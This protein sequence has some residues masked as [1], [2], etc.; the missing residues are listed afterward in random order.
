MYENHQFGVVCLKIW[1]HRPSESEILGQDPSLCI[2]KMFLSDS[3]AFAVENQKV[4]R[5]VSVLV[6]PELYLLLLWCL[7]G[8]HGI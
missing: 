6:L 4:R 5:L 7:V 2:F 3:D 8:S 1:R